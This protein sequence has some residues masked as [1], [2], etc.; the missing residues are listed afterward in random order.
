MLP[1]L[2]KPLIDPHD[3]TPIGHLGEFVGIVNH[4]VVPRY[5]H[6]LC[7]ADSGPFSLFLT[8]G[9]LA[10]SILGTPLGD[11]HSPGLDAFTK[12]RFQIS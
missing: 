10:L 7:G 1:E 12:G 4:R 5:N 9:L 3:P 6:R 11:V 2:R 8:P